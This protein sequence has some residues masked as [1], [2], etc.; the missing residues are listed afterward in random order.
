M[1]LPIDPKCFDFTLG[2]T[3]KICDM[4]VHKC[5]LNDILEGTLDNFPRLDDVAD[6]TFKLIQSHQTE[7]FRTIRID[8]QP[9]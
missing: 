4:H 6:P 5:R 1:L 2:G 8:E 7:H 3:A 9:E